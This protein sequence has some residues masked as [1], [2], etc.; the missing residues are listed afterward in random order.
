[1]DTNTTFKRLV[2]AV[3]SQTA[4]AK[5]LGISSAAVHKW[6]QLGRIPAERVIQLERLAEGQVTRYEMRPD[7]YPDEA[8]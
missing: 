1:M 3:G 6:G 4:I 7:L 5:A 2:K 8:A